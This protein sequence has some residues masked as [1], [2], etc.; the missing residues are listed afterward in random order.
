MDLSRRLL[1]GSL[2][3]LPVA[4]S[5]LAISKPFKYVVE[6]LGYTVPNFDRHG[7]PFTA[8]T[9]RIKTTDES[10]VSY[11]VI[12][13]EIIDGYGKDS[14]AFVDSEAQ[15][16]IEQMRYMWNDRYSAL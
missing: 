3:S 6:D 1:L 13:K 10:M 16:Y 4:F 7:N 2:I 11:C 5:L 9:I 8:R 15:A 14:E 12:N